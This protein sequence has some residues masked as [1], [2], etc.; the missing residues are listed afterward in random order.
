MILSLS[1]EIWFQ[2]RNPMN[3]ATVQAAWRIA[4]Y[5]ATAGRRKSSHFVTPDALLDDRNFAGNT[6]LIKIYSSRSFDDYFE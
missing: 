1:I 4:N 5:V 3:V 6:S 2:S